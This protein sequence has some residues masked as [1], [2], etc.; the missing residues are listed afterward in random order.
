MGMEMFEKARPYIAM[1][2]LQFGYAGMAILTKISLNNGMSH[3]VL[4]VYRHI[5]ATLV[6]APFAF[7]IERK[8]RPKITFQ[9]FC[10]IFALGLLGPVLDQNFYYLGLKFTSPTFGG[11]MNNLVPATTFVIALIFRMERVKI[12]EIRSQAKIVGT[13]VCVSGAMLMTLYRG[14]ILPMPWSSHDHPHS[15]NAATSHDSNSDMIKGC[16][17]LIIATL[18]WAALFVLQASVLKKYSAQL[19]LATLICLMGSLQSIAITLAVER[20]PSA[21]VIGFDMNLLTAVYSGV[22]GSGIA[23]YVQGLCMRIKGPVFA[24]A[25]VP[26]TMIISAIMDSIILHQNIYLGSVIGGVV[27]VIGLYGFLWGKA[28]D[29]KL[30]TFTSSEMLPTSHHEKNTME[31]IETLGVPVESN[32]TFNMKTQPSTV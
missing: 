24:T 26:L 15:S 2:S 9:I 23:Y 10:Q 4:V 21:W 31:S 8:I 1:T 6:L 22:V 5:V 27:I 18:A 19:S 30:T 14:A 3:Y 32:I 29:T 17:C 20:R 25:F 28:K 13:L 12:R 7:F 11:A 16:I